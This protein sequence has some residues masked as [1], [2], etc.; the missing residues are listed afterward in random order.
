VRAIKKANK[1][2]KLSP[3]PGNLFLK[4]NVDQLGEIPIERE[5]GMMRIMVCQI[6]GCAGKEVRE[7][8]MSIMEKFI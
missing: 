6:G 1:D 4:Y 7:I 8:K 2:V 5:D 3:S